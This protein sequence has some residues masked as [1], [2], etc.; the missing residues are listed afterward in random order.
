[1]G[2]IRSARRSTKLLLAL[3]LTSL[4]WLGVEFVLLPNQMSDF[5][6]AK[7]FV[8][9]QDR[10]TGCL[11]PIAGLGLYKIG[12]EARY[13][14][15][16]EYRFEPPADAEFLGEGGLTSWDRRVGLWAPA[17][18]TRN[19]SIRIVLL[20][21]RCSDP[22]VELPDVV[23]N[24]AFQIAALSR[25]FDASDRWIPTDEEII[26]AARRAKIDAAPS[27]GH[28]FVTAWVDLTTTE[29]DSAGVWTNLRGAAA[30]TL[31]LLA[32]LLMLV[33]RG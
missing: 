10:S 8:L 32:G 19:V 1:M 29:T 14:N 27:D 3:F 5:S 20:C 31:A 21:H 7:Q 9:G 13:L 23:R 30:A 28:V 12:D 6:R 11:F 26:D 15:T 4:A 17:T 2:R 18:V 25:E 22:G 16:G 33:Q 24:R